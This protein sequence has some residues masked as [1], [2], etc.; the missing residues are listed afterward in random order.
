MSSSA[1]RVSGSA[2][3]VSPSGSWIARV[4]VAARVARWR[5]ETRARGTA[6]TV[7]AAVADMAKEAMVYFADPSWLGVARAFCSLRWPRRTRDK[8]R[9]AGRRRSSPAISAEVRRVLTAGPR[10]SI[11]GALS[12]SQLRE[13]TAADTKRRRRVLCFFSSSVLSRGDAHTHARARTRPGDRRA[14]AIR[15][16]PRRVHRQLR[17]ERREGRARRR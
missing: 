14:N 2:S 1:A 16:S 15:S 4:R 10:S 11:R 9:S 8:R 3:A 6:E 13:R 5:R 7:D 12:A 17:G